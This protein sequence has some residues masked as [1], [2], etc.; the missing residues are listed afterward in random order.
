MRTSAV[1]VCARHVGYVS[2]RVCVSERVRVGVQGSARAHDLCVSACECM[3]VRVQQPM[4][5]SLTNKQTAA[6]VATDDC[7]Q[8]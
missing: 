5:E 3:R 7:V 8:H 6:P 2:E 4:R 1:A